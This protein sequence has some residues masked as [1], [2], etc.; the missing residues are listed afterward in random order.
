VDE[1]ILSVDEKVPR[2]G[3]HGF[4]TLTRGSWPLTKKSSNADE[5]VRDADGEVRNAE[6]I[7]VTLTRR[8]SGYDSDLLARE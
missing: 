4:T 8:T 3:R 6:E 7:V 2:R 5:G 1:K